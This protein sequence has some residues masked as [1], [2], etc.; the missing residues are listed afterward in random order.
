MKKFYFIG[1]VLWFPLVVVSQTLLTQNFSSGVWPPSGWTISGYT[2]QWSLNQGNQAGGTIPEGKF[3]YITGTGTSYFISPNI[4]TTG[5]TQ[6]ILDFRQYLDHYSSGYSVGVSN[7]VQP[8]EHGIMCGRLA[9]TGNISPELKSIIITN[10]DVGSSTFQFC[11]FI[12][13]N[14]YNIDY[15]YIDDISLFAPLQPGCRLNKN[16]NPRNYRGLQ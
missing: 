5:K 8:E 2:T 1:F 15:W 10:S 4:N 6:V 3:T 14:L 11:F 7:T 12:T 13:G 9:P 16:Y